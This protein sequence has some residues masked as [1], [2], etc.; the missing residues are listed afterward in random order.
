MFSP[1]VQTVPSAFKATVCV[2][3]I[4]TSGTA[5]FPVGT[6][7]TY[8]IADLFEVV[9]VTTISVLPILLPV[10]VPSLDIVAILSFND[11]YTIFDESTLSLIKLNLLSKDALIFVLLFCSNVILF[12]VTCTYVSPITSNLLELSNV[13]FPNCPFPLY[14]DVYTKPALLDITEW[15]EPVLIFFILFVSTVAVAITAFLSLFKPNL[16]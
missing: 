3:D 8:T 9:C 5:T 15:Y 16:P 12:D 1:H 13:P 6:T 2:F 10:I 7:F 11:L 14:P 4:W